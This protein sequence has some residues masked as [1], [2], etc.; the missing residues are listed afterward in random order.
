MLF[1]LKSS[2]DVCPTIMHQK[3]LSNFFFWLRDFSYQ[4]RCQYHIPSLVINQDFL[5]SIV[6]SS[7]SND[8]NLISIYFPYMVKLKILQHVLLHAT[9]CTSCINKNSYVS[10]FSNNS[11]LC[12][13]HA[14]YTRVGIVGN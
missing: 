10:Q 5:L 1:S 7:I 14:K 12:F 8:S 3:Y 4:L 13:T 11:C 2:S 6:I 9:F